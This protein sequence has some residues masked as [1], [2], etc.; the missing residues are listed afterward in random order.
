MVVVELNLGR[1]KPLST[2]ADERLWHVRCCCWIELFWIFK[3]FNHNSHWKSQ[4]VWPTLASVVNLAPRIVL[5]RRLNKRTLKKCLVR[6]FVS[7]FAFFGLQSLAIR[8]PKVLQQ[9][10]DKK[11]TVR[12]KWALLTL[13]ESGAALI[14]LDC[15]SVCCSLR[16][17]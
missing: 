7:R 4:S 15:S 8:A 6:V 17:N 11:K 16:S 13:L 2:G 10:W 14:N 12:Q 3:K 9:A 5:Y 1:A